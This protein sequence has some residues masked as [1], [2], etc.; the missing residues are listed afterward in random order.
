MTAIN[1]TGVTTKWP[2]FCARIFLTFNNL[3]FWLIYFYSATSE[4]MRIKLYVWISRFQIFLSSKLLHQISGVKINA[5]F[6]LDLRILLFINCIAISNFG[7][8]RGMYHEGPHCGASQCDMKHHQHEV[9]QQIAMVLRGQHMRFF[10]HKSK[11]LKSQPLPN[12]KNSRDES[13]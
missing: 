3:R 7:K 10:R 5:V 8:Y 2:L 13:V 6:R 1:N 4:H 11:T 12:I 9:L